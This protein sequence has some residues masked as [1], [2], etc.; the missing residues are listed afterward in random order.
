MFMTTDGQIS[1]VTVTNMNP[2]HVLAVRGYIPA[3][4]GINLSVICPKT[5]VKL[6]SQA[7]PVTAAMAA[8]LAVLAC[9]PPV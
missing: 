5:A 2:Y 8:I 4:R 9:M 7:T 1:R 3:D 6:A